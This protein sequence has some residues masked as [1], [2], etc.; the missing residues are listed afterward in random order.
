MK[1]INRRDFLK[2]AG[3]GALAVGAAACGGGKKSSGTVA[4]GTEGQM[5]YR[6]NPGNGDK[7]SLLGYGCMRWQ[8]IKDENGKDIVNQE[9]VNELVDRALEAG[10]NYF[11]TSPAYLRGQSE[12]ATG[13]ALARHP[14]NSYYIAYG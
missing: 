6:T 13:N 3:A 9:S 2:L 8:M 14:R 1:D 12:K 5:E 4:A 10:V 7:V 11:D